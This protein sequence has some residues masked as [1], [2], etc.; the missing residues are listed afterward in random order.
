MVSEK[1][2]PIVNFLA[3]RI[4]RVTVDCVLSVLG[5]PVNM[6]SCPVIKSGTFP[7]S[8]DTNNSTCNIS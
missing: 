3:C 1:D 5:D 8:N 6:F 4:C 7:E 2:I